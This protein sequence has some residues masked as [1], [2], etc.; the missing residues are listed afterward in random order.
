MSTPA[1]TLRD[2]IEALERDGELARVKTRVSPVREFAE[3]VDCMSKSPTPLPPVA[4]RDKYPAAKLGGKAL[5]FENVEGSDIPVAINTFGSY[6]RVN[7]ALGTESLDALAERVQQ[8]VKPE[9]PTTLIEKMKRLPDLIKMASFPPR[10]VRSG[11]C[12][13]G[14]PER[15]STRTNYR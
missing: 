3:V 13:E 7:K 10:G 9:I 8:L 1:P 11:I 2:L 14:G 5:L 12:Q 4:E 6:W 15:K